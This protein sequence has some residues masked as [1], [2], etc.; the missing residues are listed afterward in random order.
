MNLKLPEVN[1]PSRKWP[2]RLS[3]PSN[4]E[5]SGHWAFEFSTF[6]E[7]HSMLAPNRVHQH[8]WSILKVY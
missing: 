8:G 1:V 3:H 2:C 7:P 6:N 5:Q 4:G